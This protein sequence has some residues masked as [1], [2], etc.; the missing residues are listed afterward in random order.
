ME[1][2]LG[3]PAPPQEE[4]P[5]EEP[6]NQDPDLEEAS[7]N[8]GGS[9]SPQD[10]NEALQIVLSDD[11]LLNQLDLGAPGRFPLQIAGK[12]IPTN[13]E[14]QALTQQVQVVSAPD[15]PKDEPILIFTSIELSPSSGTF[16]YRYPAEG[17]RGT[18]YVIRAHNAWVL[19]SSR[20]SQY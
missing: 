14:L 10:L 19:K 7:N 11:A 17:V 18:S 12:D 6:S 20:V 9:V 3:Q 8:T 5:E 13:A 4:R 1:E 2:V 16:K 15:D